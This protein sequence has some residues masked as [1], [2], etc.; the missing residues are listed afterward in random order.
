MPAEDVEDLVGPNAPV[1]H[2]PAL[3][4]PDGPLP[5]E[6]PPREPPFVQTLATIAA[7]TALLLFVAWVVVTLT[8]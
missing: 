2:E 8:T 7:V 4:L 3:G 1:S 6:L 5:T